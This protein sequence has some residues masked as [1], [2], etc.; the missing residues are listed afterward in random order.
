MHKCTVNAWK[1][2]RLE[3]FHSEACLG[4]PSIDAGWEQKPVARKGTVMLESARSSMTVCWQLVCSM[5][6]QH[7]AHGRK[8]VGWQLVLKSWKMR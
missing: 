3:S 5:P 1:Q 8:A 6:R 4:H 7:W 2:V